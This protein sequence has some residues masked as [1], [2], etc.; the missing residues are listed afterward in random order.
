MLNWIIMVGYSVAKH[1]HIIALTKKTN[2]DNINMNLQPFLR[3]DNKR[4]NCVSAMSCNHPPH[5]I[6]T[7]V[8]SRGSK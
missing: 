5:K 7:P 3:K 6:Y 1:R 4:K 2:G 8:R